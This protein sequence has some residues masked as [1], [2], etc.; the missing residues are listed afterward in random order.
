MSL[1]KF[2]QTVLSVWYI[3]SMETKAKKEKKIVKIYSN[4]D[5][6]V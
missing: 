4:Y 2:G 1:S 3:F 6:F 5:H